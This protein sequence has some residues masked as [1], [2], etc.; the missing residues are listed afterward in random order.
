MEADRAE[1]Q[2]VVRRAAGVATRNTQ[3]FWS[4]L[5]LYPF[6]L[7]FG[8]LLWNGAIGDRHE[9]F[10]R[11]AYRTDKNIIF[12]ASPNR[13]SGEPPRILDL[14]CGT[15]LWGDSLCE[16]VVDRGGVG[17]RKRWNVSR[18]TARLIIRV[19]VNGIEESRVIQV[20][21]EK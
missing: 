5:M 6:T 15:I 1:I 20:N 21:Q 19:K 11:E 18:E 14:R 2:E 3:L 17:S 8:Y 10:I 13:D 16:A 4:A 9:A 7:L 12:A